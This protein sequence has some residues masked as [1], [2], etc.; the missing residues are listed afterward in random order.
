MGL[1]AVILT[2]KKP[3]DISKTIESVSFADEVIIISPKKHPI[4]DFAFERNIGISK[5]KNDWIL[6]VDDDEVISSNLAHEIQKAIKGNSN[7]AY[8]LKRLDRYHGQ[9]LRHGETGNT[10][11]IR[12]AKK[13]AGEFNRPVH[14]IWRIT[15]ATGILKNPLI[16]ERGELVNPFMNRM[17]QYCPIDATALTKEGKTFSLPRLF[18][19]PVA[20]FI[21]NYFV[22]FGFLD[23]CAGLFQAYLMSVQSLT[24]RVFQWQNI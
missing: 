22:R 5:A 9:I 1:T 2:N 20:K 10:K 8:Y 17:I 4:S 6:F 24:V 12:L 15:G 3:K 14:E 7:Q 16:H 18:L 19:N 13:T 11:I 23:G 21:Q